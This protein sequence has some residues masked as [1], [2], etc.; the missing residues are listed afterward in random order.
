MFLLSG[1]AQ[2][3]GLGAEER[4]RQQYG[5]KLPHLYAYADNANSRLQLIGLLGCSRAVYVWEAQ[6]AAHET[7][8]S[9]IVPLVS[10]S[11]IAAHGAAVQGANVCPVPPLWCC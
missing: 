6:R 4:L 2:H 5:W 9:P 10:F 7:V 11:P 3:T 1:G 8:R